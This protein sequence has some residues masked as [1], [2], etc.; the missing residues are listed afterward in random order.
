MVI[1]QR[2]CTQQRKYMLC[3]RN[4][5]LRTIIVYNYVICLRIAALGRGATSVTSQYFS[6]IAFAKSRER[7][8]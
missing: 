1:E 8:Y 4:E 2:N 5:S 3:V 7:R 6:C